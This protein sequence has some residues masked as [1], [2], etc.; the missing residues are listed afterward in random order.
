MIV[1]TMPVQVQRSSYSCLLLQPKPWSI[2]DIL[3]EGAS[4]PTRFGSLDEFDKDPLLKLL[5]KALGKIVEKP[6][7]TQFESAEGQPR[8]QCHVGT[9]DGLLFPMPSGFAFI[10]KPTIFIPYISVTK[11]DVHKTPR[12]IELEVTYLDGVRGEKTI[13]FSMIDRIEELSIQDLIRCKRLHK[14]AS[15]CCDSPEKTRN[16]KRKIEVASTIRCAIAPFGRQ[17]C[18]KGL[19][20]TSVEE[21]VDVAEAIAQRHEHV[22][23]DKNKEMACPMV[24]QVAT[25]DAELTEKEA[26]DSDSSD[27]SYEDFELSSQSSDEDFEC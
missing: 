7:G 23:A 19:S 27:A 21:K 13:C 6:L 4:M 22:D 3:P 26:D 2:V 16:K 24:P 1:L 9:N 12:Y 10:Q 8:V 14:R 18:K 25:I 20:F 11:L 17:L 15:V 5:S